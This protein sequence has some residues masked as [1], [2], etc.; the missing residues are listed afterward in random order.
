MIIY[1]YIIIIV[2]SM[3]VDF[4]KRKNIKG[5]LIAFLIMIAIG[6]VIF[7]NDLNPIYYIIVTAIPFIYWNIKKYKDNHNK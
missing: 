5:K 1:Y 4:L 6:L 3:G 2:I 7:F